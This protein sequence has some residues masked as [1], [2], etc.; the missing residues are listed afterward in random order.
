M[1]RRALAVRGLLICSEGFLFPRSSPKWD[2][3]WERTAPGLHLFV[4]D[5]AEAWGTLEELLPQ[6]ARAAKTAGT[7]K[8]SRPDVGCCQLIGLGHLLQCDSP[9]LTRVHS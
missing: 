3:P 8:V 5:A 4:R 2:F 9:H 1:R 6:Q 7:D